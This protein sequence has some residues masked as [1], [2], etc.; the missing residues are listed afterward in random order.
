M[1]AKIG[2][3]LINFGIKFFPKDFQTK[4]FVINLIK[5]DK[6]KCKGGE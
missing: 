3:I 5:I 6:I 2:I 1:K 4:G